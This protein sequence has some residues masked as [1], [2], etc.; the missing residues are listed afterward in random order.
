MGGWSFIGDTPEKKVVVLLVSCKA[1]KKGGTLKKK[2]HH[3][4]IWRRPQSSNLKPAE[5]EPVE[6]ERAVLWT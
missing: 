3:M 5:V 4:R 6:K 1:H 2:H